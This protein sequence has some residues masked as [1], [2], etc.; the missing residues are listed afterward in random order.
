MKRF[1][2]ILF[3]MFLGL[4]VV[5]SATNAATLQPSGAPDYQRS[6]PTRSCPTATPPPPPPDT[7]GDGLV[8]RK[9]SC[10]TVP[11]P[12][13]N[14]GCPLPDTSA[15]TGDRDG[16]G[17][18]DVNDQCP[19]AG[20]PALNSG[21]P[22]D[23]PAPQQPSPVPTIALP[24]LPT[25]GECVLATR[26]AERVNLRAT[27]SLSAKIVGSLDPQS[28]YP[29]LA[30]LGNAAGVW[31][32]IAQGWVAN[33][34][35]RKGGSCASLPAVQLVEAQP[36]PPNILLNSDGFDFK[37]SDDP[38]SD[39]PEPDCASPWGADWTSRGGQ[40]IH[41]GFCDGSVRPTACDGSVHPA[42][43]DGSVRPI[44]VMAV[45]TPLPVMAA[46]VPIPVMAAFIP[47]PATAACIRLPAMA[48]S[49]LR[50]RSGVLTRA[51][52]A[53]SSAGF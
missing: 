34:V 29:V 7:D 37:L 9:D 41:I 15:Q 28:L 42:S 36:G 47:L 50:R 30:T 19:D 4:A 1:L 21:C 20:G 2:L 8:D 51:L 44:P 10:P 18:P 14:L 5:A 3:G 48:A 16:D 52:T 39:P 12:A 46:S 11:G 24:A 43:C 33:W 26:N 45:F 23:Q 53:S 6:C 25:S 22:V 38:Q 32:K 40:S 13:S 35:V 17:V 49:N 27:A 31:D